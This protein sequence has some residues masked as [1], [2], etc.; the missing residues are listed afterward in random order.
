MRPAS[1]PEREHALSAVGPRRTTTAW[2]LGIAV[3]AVLVWDGDPIR[4]HHAPALHLVLDTVDACV[5]LLVASL[6][7]GRLLR[8]GSSQDLLLSQGLALLA[9]AGSGLA[10]GADRK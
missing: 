5:A 2:L 4:G 3:T 6:A 9:L 1:A 8:G 10:F 7:Y